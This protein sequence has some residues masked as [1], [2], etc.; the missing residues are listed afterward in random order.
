MATLIHTPCVFG[1]QP[2]LRPYQQ[3]FIIDVNAAFAAGQRRIIGVAPTGAG[4]TVILAAFVAVAVAEGWRVLILVHRREL[5]GQTIR[6]LAAAGLDAGVIAA[7]FDGD[8]ERPVQVAM[9]S[10]LHA[11]AVRSRRMELPPAGVLIVDE[12]HHS[13][14]R[15]WRRIVEAYPAAFLAGFTATPCRRSGSGLGVLFDTIIETPQT[16]ELID[17]GFLVPPKIYAAAAPDLTGVRTKGG[18]YVEAE[19][20]VRI[21]TGRLVGDIISH[22]H[23]H[24]AGLRTIAFAVNVAHSLHLTQE[25]NRAGAVAEH[26]DGTTP[27]AERD[28]M[29][30][31]LA[32]G[33]TDIICNCGVL[34]EGFDCPDVGC[35]VLARPTRSF[36]LFRQMSG[37]GLRPAPG[38]TH[39]VILDHAGCLLRHGWPQDPVAWTLDPRERVANKTHEARMSAHSRRL[40]DCQECGASRFEGKGCPACGWRP[41]PQ[42]EPIDVV[43][44]DL[45]LHERGRAAAPHE[46]T[47][48]ERRAFHAELL[49]LYVEF[50][51]ARRRQGK[52]DFRPG[53]VSVK[54]R[55]KFGIWP[56]SDWAADLP[57]IP[58]PATRAW[59]KSRF[60]AWHRVQQK[61]GASWQPM[62]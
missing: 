59:V 5:I 60:I 42:A 19:L 50:N 36:A 23:R 18:D 26:L 1:K 20:A 46:Y 31:R 11:R 47:T 2:T 29:L 7:G 62:G 39:C 21:D 49:G 32:D 43:D 24:A 14:A 27:A 41:R 17:A 55:D 51:Q 6:K 34:T 13:P 57:C 37:R 15:T 12:A 58:S 54:F 30:K 48:E 4:K 16:Q 52:P 56:S 10:T 22:W 35:I 40:V 33:T 61:A 8:A 3:Q 53:W 25:F 44:Q 9:I 28:A 45:V 38:K